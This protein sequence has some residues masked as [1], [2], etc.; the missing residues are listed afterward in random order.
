MMPKFVA[1]VLLALILSSASNAGAGSATSKGSWLDEA[2]QSPWNEG[3]LTVPA[4]SGTQEQ[5]DPR[6]SERERPAELPEDRLLQDRGWRLVGEFVGGW[7]LRVVRATASYDGMCR[8]RQFNAF[9]FVR[10]VLAGTLSPRAM[11]SR[12]DGALGRVV[13]ESEHRLIAQYQRYAARDPLCCPSGSTTV[14]FEMAG[15]VPV[16]R[17]VSVSTSSR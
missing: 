5:V 9:V 11:D 1:G 8:P 16:L 7:Q 3:G 13:I 4:P 10:G 17:V 15:D 2:K 12:T 14:V 6:C